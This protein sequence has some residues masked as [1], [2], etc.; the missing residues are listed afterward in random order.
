M[1]FKI[2]ADIQVMTPNK[3]LIMRE[4]DIT[5]KLCSILPI[6]HQQNGVIK[7]VGTTF[8]IDNRG[9]FLTAK[10][11][12][13]HP[14][15]LA[16]GSYGLAVPGKFAALYPQLCR[17]SRG[18]LSRT[19]N[20]A[21]YSWS[22]RGD[23]ALLQFDSPPPFLAPWRVPFWRQRLKLRI[24]SIGERCIAVGYD[25]IDFSKDFLS[26][27][28]TCSIGEIKEI[29]FPYRDSI[30]LNSPSFRTNTL[31]L[32]GMSGGPIISCD[33]HE[34]IGVVSTGMDLGI[35]EGD[36]VSFGTLI[37]TAMAFEVPSKINLDGLETI[38]E[39]ML[40]R[41]VNIDS[42][43]FRM[44]KSNKRLYS[45]IY[46]G[47]PE[48]VTVPSG[49]DLQLESGW[50]HQDYHNLRDLSARPAQKLKYA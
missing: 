43:G 17:D 6:I 1:K 13:E 21:N 32:P 25:V 8:A 9:H 49:E 12:L 31:Y 40:G 27:R 45:K 39:S 18:L 36:P 24:P 4:I 15:G 34:V 2:I 20:I 33:T 7:A 19:I 48:N 23:I 35:T 28:L 5:K 11:V 46:I 44:F 30:N 42:T 16:Y 29:Y 38:F 10:H 22:N 47:D 26:L 41:T 3:S 50:A 14:D 37:H